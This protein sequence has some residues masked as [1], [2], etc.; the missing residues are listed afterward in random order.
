[1]KIQKSLLIVF[2]GIDGSGKTSLSKLLVTYLKK[3]EL[4]VVWFREPADSQWGKRIRE[5]ADQKES[6]PVAEEI[7]YFIK[8]RQWDVTNNI[9]P[10]LE[11]DK[12]VIL[13]RYYFSTACYQGARGLD[14][15]EIIK[16]N[17]AFAPQP[18]CTFIIDVDVDTA[19]KR[20]RL[21][22]SAAV[23]LFEKRDFLQKVRENYLKL[24]ADNIY[25]IDGKPGLRSVFEKI[26]EKINSLLQL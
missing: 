18:D 15:A 4:E 12:I 24:Q 19:M 13:D 1:M 16:K 5:L 10:G 21:N 9:S 20:I 8:D 14:M 17:T 22:R 7:D 11:Q 6:I 2:E 26:K 25:I 23:K 3:K